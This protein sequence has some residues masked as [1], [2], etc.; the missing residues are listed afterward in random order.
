[1]PRRL[2][3]ELQ[4]CPNREPGWTSFGIDDAILAWQLARSGRGLAVEH[5][6]PVRD[7]HISVCEQAWVSVDFLRSTFAGHTVVVQGEHVPRMYRFDLGCWKGMREKLLRFE[8]DSSRVTRTS[9]KIWPTNAKRGWYVGAQCQGRFALTLET[10]AIVSFT[11]SIT[12]INTQLIHQ[13]VK[14]VR[15]HQ[16]ERNTAAKKTTVYVTIAG[17]LSERMAN[18]AQDVSCFPGG[19]SPDL[20][21]SRWGSNSGGNAKRNEEQNWLND[22]FQ[23]INM[24][25]GCWVSFAWAT[26]IVDQR[27]LPG[28]VMVMFVTMSWMVAG[29]TDSRVTTPLS[30]KV[31]F[32]STSSAVKVT[33]VGICSPRII[34]DTL[35]K[36]LGLTT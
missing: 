9:L 3:V 36:S 34:I 28:A 16:M 15:N 13:F 7:L 31:D 2:H 10:S 23:C 11:A 25:R 32:V 12:L 6:P 20:Y 8:N 14:E 22:L 19:V 18:L 35:R 5:E 17:G 26:S 1:M 21:V 33:G 29:V 30:S 27:A 4:L 24:Q